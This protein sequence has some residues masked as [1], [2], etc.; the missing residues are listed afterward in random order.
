MWVAQW[1]A[2]HWKVLRAYFADQMLK[3]HCHR[4]RTLA[5]IPAQMH[6]V[7][8]RFVLLILL[9]VA[10]AWNSAFGQGQTAPPEPVREFR[11]MWVAS[12]VNID[13]PSKAG[14]STADQQREFINLLNWAKQLRMNAVL[15]QVRPQGDALYASPFEPWSE[16]LTGE[17]GRAPKP[18]YD[19]LRFAVA[20]AHRRGIEL[21]AWFNPYRAHHPSA[22]SPIAASHISKAEPELVRKH[23]GYLW[24]DPGEPAIQRYSRKVILDVVKRYD[25]DGV[26]ID[27]YFYP[28]PVKG[29][30]DFPDD[31]PWMRYQVGGGRLDR[32]DWRRKNVNEFV[33][34]LYKEIKAEKRWVK[35]GVSPFGIWRPGHPPQIKGMD[36]YVDIYADSFRWFANGWLDYFSPQLYWPIEQEA[37][38]FPALLDWWAKQ[39]FQG[40]HLWPSV[41]SSKVIAEGKAAWPATQIARQV[42]ITERNQVATGNIH[43]SAKALIRLDAGLGE[44]L[45]RN[46]YKEQ[47]LVPASPWLSERTPAKPVLMMARD[48]ARKS[49]QLNWES[50]DTGG[51]AQWVLQTRR[52]SG[53]T[54]E[55]LPSNQRT[56]SIPDDA[57]LLPLAISI[58]AVNRYG[59]LSP[60]AAWVPR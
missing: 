36:A 49:I 23:N 12:I 51:A 30:P 56:R 19:P 35:F 22:R 48:S 31:V 16:F 50:G 7:C 41:N 24:M 53:W 25:I 3:R 5:L 20:E 42:L 9:T 13:W 54:T 37:Q 58:R 15:L 32:G 10:G 44:S 40:R 14:L 46:C 8:S 34:E 1:I 17:M 4:A 55:I 43:Y 39:N 57:N 27:D 45:L 29:K 11:G 59:N 52:R 33:L 2:C 38:S 18:Y 47:A 60:I 26:V 28:Y 21:H 6:C